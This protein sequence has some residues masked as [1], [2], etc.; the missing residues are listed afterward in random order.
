MK[1]CLSFGVLLVAFAG[2][3]GAADSPLLLDRSQ[4]RLEVAVHA[5]MDSF[6]ARLSSFEPVVR[7]DERGNIT[8][9]HLAF[10]FR[11]LNTGKSKRDAAMHKWQQTEAYPDGVF[12]LQSLQQTGE[13]LTAVGRLTLHGVSR[14]V[15]FPVSVARE[16]ATY[17]IDGDATIDTRE[18]DLPVIRLLGL[19][20]V[21][22]AVHVRFHV[23]GSRPTVR[24]AES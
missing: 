23:Q 12:D 3:A 6:T 8:T 20:K 24:R 13:A 22:P 10:R 1:R 18:F 2:Q 7:V 19:L 14:E 21:D 11:D 15:R 16:G 9:A 17:A 5:T 4:S